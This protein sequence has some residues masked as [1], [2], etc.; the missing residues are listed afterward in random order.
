MDIKNTIKN[1][2]KY[3]NVLIELISKNKK[4][5]DDAELNYYLFLA[6][7][8]ISQYQVEGVN[9]KN[10]IIDKIAPDVENC[11]NIPFK[12]MLIF[13]ILN[14]NDSLKSVFVNQTDERRLKN[15]NPIHP[16]CQQ[17]F[18]HFLDDLCKKYITDNIT[19]NQ[20]VKHLETHVERVHTT[21]SAL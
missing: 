11:T 9:L 13:C 21:I 10:D 16:K 4:N 2:A 12:L 6:L 5:A 7:Q 15:R 3:N 20:F 17:I 14:K 18:F 19:L 1:K 8:C